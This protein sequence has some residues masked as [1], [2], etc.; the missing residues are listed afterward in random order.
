M[1]GMT[2]RRSPSLVSVVIAVLNGEELFAAQL[3]SLVAQQ[4]DVPWELVVADNGSTDRTVDIAK[5]FASRVPHFVLVDASQQR[6][7]QFAVRQG[8]AASEGDLLAFVDHDDIC[9]P[10][11]LAALVAGA[12]DVDAVSGALELTALN[13]PAEIA[14]RPWV[15]IVDKLPQMLGGLQFPHAGNWAVWRDVWDTIDRPEGDLPHWA[16]GD[17]RVIGCMLAREGK[18]LGFAPDAVVHYRLRPVGTATRHQMRLYGRADPV[19]AKRYQDLGVRAEPL[20]RVLRRYADIVPRALKAW[21][22][23]DDA[24]WARS[25]IAYSLGRLE[26]S[27]RCRVLCL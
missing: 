1:A 10:G 8:V 27:I 17:D 4:V 22:E 2:A 16:M 13:E 26:G 20:G 21:A 3:E 14:A 5:R 6:G 19:L 7:K 12:A 25:E 15:H 18:S 9:A 11:W 24:H 23:R